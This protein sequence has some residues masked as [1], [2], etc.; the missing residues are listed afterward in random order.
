[1]TQQSETLK[2]LKRFVKEHAAEYGYYGLK[3]RVDVDPDFSTEEEEKYCT[4][5]FDEPFSNDCTD[6]DVESDVLAVIHLFR[7]FMDIKPECFQRIIKAKATLRLTEQLAKWP[8][9]KYC[10]YEP[11]FDGDDD[12]DCPTV[13]CYIDELQVV[14]SGCQA[15]IV[16][17]IEMDNNNNI[18]LYGRRA[19]PDYE[20][21]DELWTSIGSVYEFDLG[22]IQVP[23]PE[24]TE[25]A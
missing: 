17:R 15:F 10:F 9:K 18:K 6:E 11:T 23:D 3:I 16:H 12:Y 14:D 1:M 24:L 25:E 5:V 8:D 21:E 20:G 7:L 13:I 22:W 2:E 4:T 19:D